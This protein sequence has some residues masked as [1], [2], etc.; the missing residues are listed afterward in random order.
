VTCPHPPY[1]RFVGSPGCQHLFTQTHGSQRTGWR[2]L[3]P[4]ALL[5]A[6]LLTAAQWL[7]GKYFFSYV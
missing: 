3:W 4:A 7:P 5:I 6:V 1:Q 2:A